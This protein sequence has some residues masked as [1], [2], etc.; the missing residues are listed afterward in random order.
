MSSLNFA[1]AVAAGPTGLQALVRASR[2]NYILWRFLVLGSL[3]GGGAG[4]GALLLNRIATLIRQRAESRRKRKL[5]EQT[6]Q[7]E[8][9]K[10]SGGKNKVAVDKIFYARLRLILGICIPRIRSKPMVILTMHS[11]FLIL[12]TYLSIIVARLDGRLVKDLV[13]IEGEGEG[14]MRSNQNWLSVGIG[15][16]VVGLFSQDHPL[17]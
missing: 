5:A 16:R 2:R 8:T 13:R 12:R 7:R 6:Q 11:L 15:E 17:N 1:T 3:V 10:S 4:V 9:D 14:E